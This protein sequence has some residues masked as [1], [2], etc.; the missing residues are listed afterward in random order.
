MSDPNQTPIPP[1]TTPAIFSPLTPEQQQQ[2][3]QLQQ[4]LQQSQQQQQQ[5][6][7]P[8]SFAVTATALQSHLA[9]MAKLLDDLT[10]DYEQYKKDTEARLA[11][12]KQTEHDLSTHVNDV[13]QAQTT[14]R[15]DLQRIENDLSNRQDVG[16]VAQNLDAVI[17][18]YLSTHQSQPA[19]SPITL[20][21]ADMQDVIKDG[22][23]AFWQNA[24]SQGMSPSQSIAATGPTPPSQAQPPTQV[25]VAPATQNKKLMLGSILF[26]QLNP[27]DIATSVTENYSFRT[28]KTHQ[29]WIKNNTLHSFI[30]PHYGLAQFAKHCTCPIRFADLLHPT[31]DGYYINKADFTTAYEDIFATAP[32]ACPTWL[33]IPS[34]QTPAYVVCKDRIYA[35]GPAGKQY[36]ESQ[37]QHITVQFQP[38]PARDMA[39][40]DSPFYNHSGHVTPSALHPLALQ[41]CIAFYAS[42]LRLPM[43]RPMH[44][45][46]F[47]NSKMQ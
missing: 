44:C 11:S 39:Q 14:I 4:Q 38:D 43:I 12:S 35:L 23:I 28:D 20:S 22:L 18:Q 8:P 16:T 7:Q 2:L 30:S 47:P 29:H 6:Q 3:Q 5:Q 15:T 34:G 33:E 24:S 27:D 42:A 32:T 25:V 9:V 46:L 45:L 37:L 1:T 17:R 13:R 36:Y 26:A 31:I 21:R 10:K 19:A 41:Y 40:T